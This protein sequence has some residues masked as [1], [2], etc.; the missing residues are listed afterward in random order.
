MREYDVTNLEFAV[1][2][3]LV[4]VSVDVIIGTK[5]T[6]ESSHSVFLESEREFTTL[7]FMMCFTLSFGCHDGEHDLEM[8]DRVRRVT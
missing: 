2:V 8:L 1:V 6:S 5:C 7:D 4:V 3:V